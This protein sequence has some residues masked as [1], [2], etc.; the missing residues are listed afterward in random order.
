MSK[1][2]LDIESGVQERGLGQI[3]KFGDQQH[4]YVKFEALGSE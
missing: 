3:H 2:Q 1:K 4:M